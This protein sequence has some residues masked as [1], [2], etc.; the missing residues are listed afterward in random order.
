M[1]VLGSGG[2]DRA[3]F[4]TSIYRS[5]TNMKTRCS[6]E[7]G[8]DYCRY[9]ARGIAVC[10]KW[11]T[12]AG[13]YEDMGS[14]YQQGLSI[15]RVDNDLGYYKD[16]CRWATPIEQANNRRSSRRITLYGETKTLEQWIRSQGL[17]SSTVRQR[18]Y[19]LKWP[20]ERALEM[21]VCHR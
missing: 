3:L 16:N 9:G 20:A 6:N 17:K 12:F 1:A 10:E 7:R 13:F 2:Y 14:T 19:V 5:W 8:T 18:I 4:Q 21:E 11:K 15:E